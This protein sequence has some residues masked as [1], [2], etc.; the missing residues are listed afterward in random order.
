MSLVIKNEKIGNDG[1]RMVFISGGEFRMGSDDGYKEE[2]PVMVVTVDSFYI[3]QEL[4]TNNEYKIFCDATGTQYPLDPGWDE[5]TNYFLAFANYPV[6]NVSWQ[7]ATEYAKWVG[8]RLPTEKE[9][10]YAACGG[11]NNPIYPWGNELASGKSANFAD[12]NSDLPWREFRIN[13]KYKFTSSVGVYSKNGYGLADMAGNVWEWCEDWFYNYEDTEHDESN[14]EDG[15]GGSKVCRGGCYHS[16]NFDLRVARRRQILGGIAQMSVGFRCVSSENEKSSNNFVKI[17]EKEKLKEG[18]YEIN[19]IERIDPVH[20]EIKLCMGTGML[21][22]EKALRIKKAGFSSVEQYVTWESLQKKGR[23]FWDFSVWDEQVTIIKSVGLK[24]MPFLIL[25]PAYSLPK[26]YLESSEFEGLYCLEHNIESK[27]QSIW[28]KNSYYYINTFLEKVAEH[29]KNFDVIESLI[30]GISG[31]FGESIF[32]VWHGNWP[33]QIAG[34]YHSHEGY[35]CNDRKARK[36]FHEFLEEKYQD[37][38]Q[39]NI[40]WDKNYSSFSSV[41]FPDLEVD[42]VEGFRVD[43]YT[44]CG[45]FTADSLGEQNMWVDFIDWYRKS[46]ND[47]AD[48]WMKC[49]RKHFET[50]PIYLCTGGNAL[51]SHGANF[52]QQCK[53]VSKYGGGIR[54]TNEASNYATNFV[55]T[56]WVSSSGNFYGA[57]FS[58]EPAGKVT[59]KGVVCRIYNALATGADGLHFYE[60]NLF[61]KKSKMDK[62]GETKKFLYKGKTSKPIGVVYPDA[63]LILGDLSPIEFQLNFELLREYTD[64]VFLDETTINDGILETVEVVMICCGRIYRKQLIE[65]LEKWL[66]EGGVLIGYNIDKIKIL[67]SE[68][69]HTDRLFDYTGSIKKYGKGYSLY[70]P[71]EVL[72]NRNNQLSIIGTK[73]DVIEL[74]ESREYYQ[75]NIFDC[76]TSFLTSFGIYIVNGTFN[77]VYST[78]VDDKVILMNTDSSEVET[79]VTLPMGERLTVRI[80][81]NCIYKLD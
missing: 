57:F 66:E 28:N 75:K 65:M 62:F 31:D 36:N 38:K 69:Q 51:P 44:N 74:C 17:A 56:N 61:D 54:I 18:E 3:D 40:I 23:E 80:P 13:T 7:N 39:L 12:K 68:E 11:L 37:I 77:N 34:L 63:S 19:K 49:A 59:E 14:F 50:L 16:C 73:P 64:Y 48:F 41:A 67:E 30:L 22:I 43:E 29:F 2:K 33:T 81:G 32:P 21:T 42:E 15:W 20:K 47:Y 6:A 53:V 10:E 27:V 55:V 46:M 79:E 25:G 45:T 71:I 24:W 78:I 70:I 1:K 72:P 52:A 60:E 4:V 8:K 76:I 9:W 26:W 35:W 5:M 58:F